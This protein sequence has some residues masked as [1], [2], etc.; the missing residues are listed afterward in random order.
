MGGGGVKNYQKLRDVIY[1]RPLTRNASENLN[2]SWIRLI[3][4]RAAEAV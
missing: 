3:Q 1:R 2:R 4:G